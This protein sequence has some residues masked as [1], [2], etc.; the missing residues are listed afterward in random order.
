MKAAR[1]AR[2]RAD[3]FP[4]P[5]NQFHLG[6]WFLPVSEEGAAVATSAA[7]ASAFQRTSFLSELPWIRLIWYNKYSVSYRDVW[8]KRGGFF[9]EAL[10]TY[11][12]NLNSQRRSQTVS[13]MQ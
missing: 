3:S 12:R 6:V 13:S 10:T 4:I 8:T 1:V 7:F 5:L 11:V 2:C 9:G